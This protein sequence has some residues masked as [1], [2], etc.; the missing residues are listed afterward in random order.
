MASH[1]CPEWQI[2]IRAR[3]MPS[4]L[5]GPHRTGRPPKCPKV[6]GFWQPPSSHLSFL[7]ATCRTDSLVTCA[8]YLCVAQERGRPPVFLMMF[9]AKNPHG[10]HPGASHRLLLR[11]Q[12]LRC[13]APQGLKAQAAHVDVISRAA[14]LLCCCTAKFSSPHLHW[15]AQYVLHSLGASHQVPLHCPGKCAHHAVEPVQAAPRSGAAQ[16]PKTCKLLAAISLAS[17]IPHVRLPNK[18]H[19]TCTMR[20]VSVCR[21]A[22]R[23]AVGQ[24][25]MLDVQGLHPGA[26]Y[27]TLLR[28]HRA[29]LCNAPWPERLIAEPKQRMQFRRALHMV[30]VWA[31]PQGAAALCSQ[32]W[33]T[34]PSSLCGPHRTGRPP[35]YPKLGTFWQPSASHGGLR[36]STC[37][38]K[39]CYT[40]RSQRSCAACVAV[41]SLPCPAACVVSKSADCRQGSRKKP[42]SCS[43]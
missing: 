33:P 35:G 5:C 14:Q 8:M 11:S 4:S 30:P 1:L 37:T 25:K 23:Q 16:E 32:R 22:A 19:L 13:S 7:K 41:A 6:A 27:C 28:H 40:C 18:Q 20:H 17:G 39:Q 29:M 24:L 2:C 10:L 12:V 15:R 26:I 21:T 31:Q 42:A 38:H 9:L 43:R 34:M 3:T 36:K